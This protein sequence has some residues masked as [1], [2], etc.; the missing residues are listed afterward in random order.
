MLNGPN[1]FEFDASL[2]IYDVQ[3]VTVS[4]CSISVLHPGALFVTKIE[5]IDIRGFY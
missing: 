4:C 5:Y 2:T 3:P 1:A